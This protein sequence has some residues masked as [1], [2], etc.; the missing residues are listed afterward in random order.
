MEIDVEYHDGLYFVY[1]SMTSKFLT[2]DVDEISAIDTVHQ[3]YPD[4]LLLLSKKDV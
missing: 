3:Q 2:K 1:D 4:Y